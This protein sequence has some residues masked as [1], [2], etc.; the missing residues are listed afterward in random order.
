MTEFYL[1]KHAK[2]QRLSNL[3]LICGLPGI[4]NVGKIAMDYMIESLK[5]EKILEIFSDSLPHS[6]FV[7]ENNT[8]EL[9]SIRIYTHKGKKD[10]ILIEGDAQP[11]TEKDSYELSNYLLNITQKL[12]CKQVVTLGGIGRENPPK[13]PKV[14][15]TATDE[16]TLKF[17]KDASKDVDFKIAGSVANIFGVSG[18][19][20]GLAKLKGLTGAAFLVDTLAHPLHLGFEEARELV[21]SLSKTFELELDFKKLDK[22]IKESKDQMEL[23]AKRE[24]EFSRVRKQ[25]LRSDMS[26]IG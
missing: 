17:Y 23:F 25:E 4:G 12:G 8:V 15:G 26:Y 18:V 7:N 9:P 5:C 22:E 13:K 3:I 20:L 6:V 1:K 14:Y 2:P 21:K 19:L 10:F 11:L 16:E 24:E